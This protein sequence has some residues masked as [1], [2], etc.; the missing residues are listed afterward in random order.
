MNATGLALGVDLVVLV[1]L[2]G[3]VAVADIVDPVRAGVLGCI[4]TTGA[5]RRRYDGEPSA[6]RCGSPVHRTP[7][8]WSSISLG[9][10]PQGK[11]NR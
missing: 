10:T 5:S 1:V 6:G 9:W 11:T 8:R 7:P 4:P 2:I 3:V